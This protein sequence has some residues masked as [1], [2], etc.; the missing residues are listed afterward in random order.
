MKISLTASVSQRKTA[1]TLIELL[2]VIAIIAI[3]A[4]ILFPVFARARENARRSSC[5]SNLKQINLGMIQYRQ[6]Y[7]EKFVL[8]QPANSAPFDESN[9]YGWADTIQ[10]YI[11]NRQVFHCPSGE[12]R[13]TSTV[14]FGEVVPA[15]QSYTDYGY[16]SR[17]AFPGNG[18]QN[19]AS[20]SVVENPTLSVILFE[21]FGGNARRGT[22]G[23]QATTSTNAAPLTTCVGT[24]CLAN[25][26][27]ASGTNADG[28]ALSRHLEG[29]NFAFID[30]HV[31]WVKAT[32]GNT[33]DVMAANVYGR[34]VPF[35]LSSNNPTFHFSDSYFS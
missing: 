16:S 19:P 12:A 28:G 23:Q 25:M 3:L 30:G 7:D 2:V 33:S 31:K 18:G 20:E 4:A 13:S 6:D 26:R 1:F 27:G 5:Q 17:L 10:P 9:T 22:S 29:S 32:G 8:A 14:N 24:G 35:S 11:K 15:V 21:D 34:G